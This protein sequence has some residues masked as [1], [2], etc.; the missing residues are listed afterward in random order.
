MAYTRC[1]YA[2]DIVK[3]LGAEPPGK[4]EDYVPWLEEA[5]AT[6]GLSP[7]VIELV[8]QYLC[9]GG[10]VDTDEGHAA[11]LCAV[12][13][14]FR[15]G[16]ASLRKEA[17]LSI[18][19]KWCA[20]HGVDEGDE[21]KKASELCAWLSDIENNAYI[22]DTLDCGRPLFFDR[23]RGA[24]TTPRM[25]Q[26]QS[27]IAQEIGAHWLTEAERIEIDASDPDLKQ[28]NEAQIAAVRHFGHARLTVVTGGPG[29]GKTS[30]VV[31]SILK[32]GMRHILAKHGGEANFNINDKVILTA[33][34]GKAAQR[35]KE[36]IREA[37]QRLDDKALKSYFDQLDAKTI[38]RT[39]SFKPD[40]VSRYGEDEPL[41]AE[42]I[43]VDEASMLALNMA[44]RLFEALSSNPSV[45]LVLVGDPE[46][47]PPVD[48]GELLSNFT[49]DAPWDTPFY[50][51]LKKCRVHLN[52]NYR[53]QAIDENKCDNIY[54][55]Q[56]AVI[57]G[58][59][60]SI[61]KVAPIQVSD[62]RW[63]DFEY[64]GDMSQMPMLIEAWVSRMISTY[65]EAWQD[66]LK[67]AL[68]HVY[69]L[70]E[71][72]TEEERAFL[73]RVFRHLDSGYRV[74][75]PVNQGSCGTVRLNALIG[76]RLGVFRGERLSA[77]NLVM[78]TQNQYAMGHFNGETGLVIKMGPKQVLYAAF[79]S[80][81]GGGRYDFWP[82]DLI[83][84]YLDLAFAISIHKSQGSEY[85][86]GLILLPPTPSML[87]TRN[88]LYTAI[89]R[90]K[91]SATLL[92]K[93]EI[94]RLCVD[95]A[96]EHD[97]VLP[98]PACIRPLTNGE[99]RS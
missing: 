1:G 74:L 73:D 90:T 95:T 3:K 47:L 19:E 82:L 87:L 89:S 79:P 24:Y 15:S 37:S 7:V 60:A 2:L 33:P 52:K 5:E 57:R 56:G 30:M 77:G 70:P 66:D 34:T 99:A 35:M 85:A 8:S 46:Q 63:Q 18:L 94:F 97:L 23:T 26:M 43:I 44:Y 9:A 42:L 10:S 20:V 27:R 12:F 32:Y 4:P 6:F 29:T 31:Y 51:S 58:D 50:A 21:G 83:D 93:V 13:E 28:A 81:D 39:L 86:H 16:H 91:R 61:E 38:H 76:E 75:T 45:R 71:A 17:L 49:S 40:S 68:R 53:I 55:V 36:A 92:S 11:G 72:M 14:H 59:W 62:I 25:F 69:S 78:L 41:G 65:R 48:T 54:V 64:C 84:T 88:L 67:R 98:D 96:I 22:T 80:A